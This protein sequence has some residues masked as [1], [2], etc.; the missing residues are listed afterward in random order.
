MESGS[1]NID[2]RYRVSKVR[3]KPPVLVGGKILGKI[4]G[5]ASL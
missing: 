4:L 2:I 1:F 3:E 5:I